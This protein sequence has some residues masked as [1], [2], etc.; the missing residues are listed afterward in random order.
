[1]MKKWTYYLGC[2][3]L[4]GAAT[5]VTSCSDDTDA[6]VGETDMLELVAYSQGMTD[7]DL[8][9]T[10]AIP[11]GYTEYTG[12]SSIGV[13]TTSAEVAPASVRTFSYATD[14]WKSLVSV[15]NHDTY[16]IYGYMPASSEIQCT[17]SKRTGMDYSQGAVLTFTD[18]PPVLSEDFSVVTGVQQ[19]NTKTD[20]VNLVPGVF[21][22]T[23]KQMGSNFACLMLDHLYSCVRFQLKVDVEYGNLRTIKLKEVSLKTTNEVTY[24]LVVTMKAGENYTVTWGTATN[25]TNDFMTLFTNKEGEQLSAT[26]AKTV[27]GYFAPFQNIAQNL[28]VQ[29]KYDVYGK[30]KTGE[31]VLT[32]ED[33][34]ATN[35]L[36]ANNAIKYGFNQ[37]T[38]LTLTVNPTYLYVL[39]EPDLD[40]PT[41][42]VK[43]E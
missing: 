7:F 21:Q 30:D 20:P 32:R 4:L 23:G 43:S 9:S 18:L 3:L 15:K 42:E 33:C 14:Q 25:R 37:R 27:D 19:L 12:P 40:D 34:V 38:L 29:C 31:W 22:F 41:I 39:S 17:I 11:A 26:N 28:V 6:T 1:M 24:P 36:P 2:L 5:L 10:R 13:F 35:K 8:L 16:Y